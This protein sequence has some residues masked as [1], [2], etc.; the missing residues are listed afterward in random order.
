MSLH[1]VTITQPDPESD[2]Y[3]NDITCPGD[4]ESC[5]SWWECDTCQHEATTNE[6]DRS[7]HQGHGVTHRLIE[8]HWMTDSQTCS[9]TQTDS[10]AQGLL[11]VAERH[12]L[13]THTIDVD[14]WGDG[15][16]EITRVETPAA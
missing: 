4:D 1:T 10:G 3:E 5:Y 8:G 6:I 2:D 15:H 13:G 7:E 12:G 16:W 11:D 14:Y 9:L